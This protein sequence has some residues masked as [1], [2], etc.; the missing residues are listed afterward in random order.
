MSKVEQKLVLDQRV[1]VSGMYSEIV[2]ISGVQNNYYQL[3]PDGTGF[4]NQIIFQNILTPS[5]SNTIVGKNIRLRY[6]VTATAAADCFLPKPAPASGVAVNG[7]LRAWPLQTV[8]DNVQITLNGTTTTIAQKYVISA[9]QRRLPKDLL[10]GTA[11]ECPTQSDNFAA[12]FP[13]AAGVSNQVLSSYLNSDGTTR[14]SFQAVS[15][16]AGTNTYTFEV[17]ESLLI[18]PFTPY[19]DDSGIPLVNTLSL[20]LNYSNLQQMFVF[21]AVGGTAPPVYPAGFTV[22]I[23]NPTIDLTYFQVSNSVVKIDPIHTTNYENINYYQKAAQ[24]AISL[25][26]PG[27]TTG[28]SDTLRLSSMPSLIAVMLRFPDSYY[29]TTAGGQSTAD[30][31]FPIGNAPGSSN[32]LCGLSVSLG[33]R[34]GLLSSLDV[35]SAYK[36]SKRNG[37]NGSYRE[38]LNCGC[39]LLIDPTVDLGID[40]KNGDPFPGQSGSVNLQVQ[41]V[42][43]NANIIA[44]NA[45]AGTP[46]FGAGPINP[47][48]TVVV[49]LAGKC[50]ISADNCVF[51]TGYLSEGELNSLLRTAPTEGTM[52]SSAQIKGSDA[53]G[54]GLFSN[55]KNILSHVARG[56]GSIAPV[57]QTVAQHPVTQRL[58]KGGVLTMA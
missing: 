20:Q 41:A 10:K 30:V 42:Y 45:Y 18:S 21:G 22:S 3:S 49:V 46:L 4:G 56:I 11:S 14:G 17:C 44:A 25:T 13:D 26:A 53:K 31:L 33:N 39:V 52:M 34:T 37:F 28:T 57:V 23:S 50:A 8:C 5:V 16:D 15:F 2:R 9:T 40:A 29:Q 43:N 55:M 38:W 51:S 32:N 58:A 48:L 24:P 6:L 36:M 54:A 19:D 27:L 1:N 7:V 47:V 12:L 35:E